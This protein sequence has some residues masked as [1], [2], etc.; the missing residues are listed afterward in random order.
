MPY[1]TREDSQQKKIYAQLIAYDYNA[2]QKELNY[3]RIYEEKV[4]RFQYHVIIQKT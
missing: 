2:D 1:V 4:N 3:Y